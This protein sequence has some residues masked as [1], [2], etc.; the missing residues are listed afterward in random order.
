METQRVPVL[1][2]E[3]PD[4][5]SIFVAPA[6]VNADTLDAGCFFCDT[7][8]NCVTCNCDCYDCVDPD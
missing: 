2:D 7:C 8:D 1:P 3:M 4:V 5:V 6:T